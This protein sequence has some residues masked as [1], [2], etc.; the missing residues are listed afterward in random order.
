V[1]VPAWLIVWR[2]V[3]TDSAAREVK[4]C[5]RSHFL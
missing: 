3:W 5:G 1:I 2:A 4:R